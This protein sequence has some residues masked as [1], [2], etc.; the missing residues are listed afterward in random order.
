MKSKV[1]F[2]SSAL[3]RRKFVQVAGIGAAALTMASRFAFAGEQTS[4]RKIRIG[5]IGGNFG[6]GFYFH[7]HPNCTVEAVSDLLPDRREKLMKVY[8]CSKSY[9]SSGEA[10]ARSKD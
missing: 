3:N 8:K 7:E 6:L 10:F 4:T 1:N 2:S 5:I 9:E